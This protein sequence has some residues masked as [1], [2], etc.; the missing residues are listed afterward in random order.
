MHERR[1]DGLCQEGG[2]F[3][4]KMRQEE[5]EAETGIFTQPERSCLGAQEEDARH[6]REVRQRESSDELCRRR[7]RFLQ[8]RSDV[9]SCHGG[10]PRSQDGDR[11]ARR[12]ET[13][14]V[15]QS[16]GGDDPL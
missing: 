2:E 10:L 15:K 14:L 11:P 3:R 4:S 13:R 8:R 7:K 16:F 12:S 5:E 9:V 6:L 1:L